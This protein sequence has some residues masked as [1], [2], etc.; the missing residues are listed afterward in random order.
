[1]ELFMKKKLGHSIK[2]T[3][4]GA[5]AGSVLV[6]S[7]MSMACSNKVKTPNMNIT[8]GPEIG[9]A[10]GSVDLSGDTPIISIS[11]IKSEAGMNIEYLS[12]V[13]IENEG[14]FPDLEIWVD[15]STVDIFTPGN[16]TAIYTFNYG[17]N[18]FQK[19]SL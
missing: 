6:I 16:Y 17:D 4:L 15:A 18:Q 9:I 7:C 8:Y 12:G 1:M 3:I 11:A 14:D 5:L 2:Y 13:T 10:D 19:K